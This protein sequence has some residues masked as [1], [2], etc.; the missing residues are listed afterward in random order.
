M[1]F[2]NKPQVLVCTTSQST[3]SMLKEAYGKDFKLTL[4]RGTDALRTAL[5][6]KVLPVIF[7]G[8]ISSLE[9]CM[10]YMEEYEEKYSEVQPY[11]AF[12]LFL[13]DKQLEKELKKQDP[14]GK[15]NILKEIYESDIVSSISN[16]N[17]KESYALASE[18]ITVPEEANTFEEV[19]D[20]FPKAKAE[21]SSNSN[22]SPVTPS[23]L[24]EVQE[25]EISEEVSHVSIGEVPNISE[26]MGSI[27]TQA[28]VPGEINEV[29]LAS[30]QDTTP[31]T[32]VSEVDAT[33]SLPQVP[34]APATSVAQEPH[35]GNGTSGDEGKTSQSKSNGIDYQLAFEEL[36]A[37]HEAFIVE[38]QSTASNWSEAYNQLSADK[39]KIEQELSE[40]KQNSVD[41]Q[42]SV[43]A[44]TL[45]KEFEAHEQT[46]VNIKNAINTQAEK[47]IK[48][49][50]ILIKSQK[51][52][53][54][55]LQRKLEE[56]EKQADAEA[57]KRVKLQ[58]EL[59]EYKQLGTR[60]QEMMSSFP[61]ASPNNRSSQSTQSVN[62]SVENRN[63]SKDQVSS[64]QDSQ[65][66]SENK[67]PHGKASNPSKK[68]KNKSMQ[69]MIQ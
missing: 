43:S 34:E 42:S 69:D 55:D 27:S 7:D 10:E 65:S 52:T 25:T 4:L 62:R 39:Q 23:A 68:V 31:S 8:S 37:K 17:N 51:E 3:F 50:E 29:E 40:V 49:K 45:R 44:L 48:D 63:N 12:C 67:N 33:P 19:L 30:E 59:E 56:K 24:P 22:S 11:Q 60:F 5:S 58:D 26:L 14:S 20:I 28:T 1:K 32:Q 15:E 2:F 47:E 18:I 16:I 21:Y 54:K 35:L 66:H 57:V 41:S 46:M 13:S 9:S 61:F 53:I 38:A 64:N 6:K 36:K